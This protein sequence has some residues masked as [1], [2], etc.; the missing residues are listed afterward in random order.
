MSIDTIVLLYILLYTQPSICYRPY[1]RRCCPSPSMYIDI[2][3]H[4]P[5]LWTSYTDH[6]VQQ[7][8]VLQPIATHLF[9]YCR[10]LGSFSTD[11]P[12]TGCI[13]LA[14][15][16][17]VDTSTRLP[18]QCFWCRQRTHQ[19]LPTINNCTSLVYVSEFI[20]FYF[21]SCNL[22]VDVDNWYHST[23]LVYVGEF[24]FFIPSPLPTCYHYHRYPP[25]M[26]YLK[27]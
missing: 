3:I 16:P 27:N 22:V 13:L 8:T 26:K 21:Y 6:G 10:L 24:I 25:V 19:C 18:M 20:L 7:Y 15:S 14:W 17:T 23:H 2:S 9:R 4:S 11:I 5:P 1:R 12:I